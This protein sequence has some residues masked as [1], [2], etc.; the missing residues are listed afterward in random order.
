[1]STLYDE[2]LA[3]IRKTASTEDI[4]KGLQEFSNDELVILAEELATISKDPDI[5]AMAKIL[6]VYNSAKNVDKL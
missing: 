3:N 4:K 5:A 2:L 6:P 1:M